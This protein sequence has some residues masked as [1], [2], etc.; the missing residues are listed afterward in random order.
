V[1]GTHRPLQSNRA[2]PETALIKE[3][4]NPA[5]YG[6]SSPS[7]PVHC[8]TGFLAR[9][10]STD[11]HK[12]PHRICHGILSPL[13]SGTQLLSRGRFKHQI[14][15]HLPARGELACREYSDHWN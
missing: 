3:A 13:V 8:S 9:G 10:E 7:R 6:T 14:S 5:W 12:D 11:T 4:G 15:G 2:G 1:S